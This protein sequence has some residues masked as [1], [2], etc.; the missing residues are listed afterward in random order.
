MFIAQAHSLAQQPPQSWVDVVFQFSADPLFLVLAG[1][2]WLYLRGLGRLRHG[3]AR[4]FRRWR[5]ISFFCGVGIYGIALLS[6]VD[7][8]ADDSFLLH[9]VQHMLMMLVA[10]PLVLLGAPYLPVMRGL[11][12]GLRRVL[13]IPIARNPL[14]RQGIV[15]LFRPI[16]A[17]IIFAGVQVVWHKPGVYNAALNDEGVHY[18]EHVSFIIGALFFWWNIIAPY[19]FRPNLP[20][21]ARLIGLVFS[22]VVNTAIS[23]SITFADTVLYGY[24]SVAGLPGLSPKEDQVIGGALMWV[25]GAMIY[26]FAL[27]CVFAAYSAQE[28]RKEPGLY[29]PERAP[30][31]AH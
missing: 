27:A 16:P 9:M 5:P 6:F 4:P 23:A 13:V 14:F 17:F 7:V 12:R 22:S 26:L 18:A 20:H 3:N 30:G 8:W 31:I 21:L 15:F 11:P 1:F 24:G 10:M 2:A 25:M 28:A 29:H 19:P